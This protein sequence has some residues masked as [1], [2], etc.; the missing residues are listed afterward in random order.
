MAEPELVADC[1]AAMR[2]AV[3]MPV[4]VKC[5]IGIDARTTTLLAASSSAVAAAGCD[6][7]IVHARKAWLSGLQPEGEPGDPAAALRAGASAQAG[8]PGLT[9]VI[10]GGIATLEQ[11]RAQ[12]AHVDG[13]MLGREAYQN[14]YG[15]AIWER[16]LYA[17]DEPLPERAG[18]IEHLLPYIERELAEGTPL[19]AITRHI[20]GLFNGLPGARAWR[21]HLSEAAHR[22]GAGA[23]VL[24]EALARIRPAARAAA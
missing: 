14:P 9:M 5:R 22:E 7:F 24:L 6:T 12:L 19:R 3:G 16:A 8:F 15:L 21:R 11:A 10:N 1:V 13:V 2:E 23:E 17:S 4:T 20:L 18:I